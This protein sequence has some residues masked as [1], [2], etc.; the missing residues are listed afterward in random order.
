M[1]HLFGANE[2]LRK[3]RDEV[4]NSIEYWDNIISIKNGKPIPDQKGELFFE[5]L[6]GYSLSEIDRPLELI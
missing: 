6:D 5:P 3:L 2:Q 4:Y 1:N